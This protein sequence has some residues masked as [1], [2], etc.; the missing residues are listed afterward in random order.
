MDTRG[1]LRPQ[2]VGRAF[3]LERAEPSPPLER[4]VAG[5]WAVAWQLP[6]GVVRRS[7][8]LP[9][10][11]LH[12][13]VEPHGVLV[14]GVPLALDVR[15]LAD[16]GFAVGTRFHPGGFGGL[17]DRPVAELT[18]RVLPAA[19][20]F[21]ADGARLERAAA[22]AGSTAARIA[23]L[24]AFLRERL[25]EPTAES[26]L[27]RAVVDDIA[28]AQPGTTV[29]ALAAR[30]AVS[31]RTLQRLFARHVGVGPKWVLRR[32]RMHAAL[33]GLARGSHTDWTRFAL[34]L[35][36]FDHA[37]FIRDFRAVVGRTPAQY[38]REAAA[39]AGRDA[40]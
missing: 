4:I 19:E 26:A 29:A 2:Q 31:T 15:T 20:V 32:L 30:H 28:T 6:P 27:V 21:G 33:E 23:V 10:P 22:E 9:H 38:A 5:H 8:V 40:A 16:A 12:L 7:E 25:P 17:V 39:P 37:H 34:D 11:A 14:Y 35:G 3:T 36:Y 1:I 13:T 18:G 24:E